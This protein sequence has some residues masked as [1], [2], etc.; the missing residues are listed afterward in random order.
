M[1]CLAGQGHHAVLFDLASIAGVALVSLHLVP[2]RE[3]PVSNDCR[4]GNPLGS[5]M[6]SP[7]PRPIVGLAKGAA[8]LDSYCVSQ[9]AL[10]LF[11]FSL[12]GSGQGAV[13]LIPSF[14]YSLLPC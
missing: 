12:L 8:G 6:L 11:F 10:T 2:V 1:C 3:L 13:D 7:C 4:T 5:T 14:S 9:P